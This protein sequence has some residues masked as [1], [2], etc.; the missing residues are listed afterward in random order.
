MTSKKR[1]RKEPNKP[2][3]QLTS[4]RIS[5]I[6]AGLPP[7][8]YLPSEPKLAKQLGVS[9]A[10]LREAM[11]GLEQRG[12]IVR[13]QGIGTRVAEPPPIIEAGLEVLESIETLAN[14]IGLEAE[15]AN[16]DI[17]VRPVA[18][19]EKT[20][21]GIN[22]D[23]PLVEISRLMQIQAQPVAY[24]IDVVPQELLP[25]SEIK[26]GFTGSVLDIF[27]LRSQPVL[28]HSRT[29]I[30]TLPA[31]AQ[32]AHALEIQR[33]DFL[34]HLDAYL[35]DDAGQVIDHSESYFLPGIIHFHVIRTVVKPEG[36]RL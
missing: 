25:P 3:Y 33:G 11:R 15:M 35:Y 8:A 22:E 6:L 17:I 32:V 14:R 34:L 1:V 18:P 9:R 29:E 4:K 27:F 31:P 30:N 21:F 13:R 12:L 16:L 26:T 19:D 24:L 7:G 36:D 5:E 20:I 2:L 23:E 10:T 28:S